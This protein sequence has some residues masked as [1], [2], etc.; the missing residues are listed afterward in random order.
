MKVPLKGG[1]VLGHSVP[2]Q[3]PRSLQDVWPLMVVVDVV[4]VAACLLYPWTCLYCWWEVLHHPHLSL[5][6]SNSLL[7]L[8]VVIVVRLLLLRRLL[9]LSMW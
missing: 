9:L 6:L 2:P 5:S 1:Q 3:S 8:W 4:V 7:L